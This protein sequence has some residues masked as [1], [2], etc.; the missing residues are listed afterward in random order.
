MTGLPGALALAL[1]FVPL[2]QGPEDLPPPTPEQLAASIHVWTI[3]CVTT[4]EQVSVEGGEEVVR[5]D[6][7]ILFAFGSDALSDVA[8]QRIGEL[9]AGIDPGASVSVVGH[10]DDVGTD[11]YNLDLSQRRAAA[12]AAALA[13]ARPDLVLAVEGRGESEPVEPNRDPEGREANRRV[14]LRVAP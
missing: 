14:E 1:A 8:S 10:T 5:L 12:V 7:D 4:L 9:G 2:Q 6:S 11:R 13:A 3:C